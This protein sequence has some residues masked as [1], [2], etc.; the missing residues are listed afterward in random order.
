MPVST[1]FLRGVL[2]MLCVFFAY[3]AGRSVGAVRQGWS[4]LWRL[5]GWIL[6]TV[7]CG[8]VMVFRQ[9]LDGVV[10]AVWALA[11]MAF[12]GGMWLVLHQEPPEDLTHQI[13]PE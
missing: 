10:I 13:F 7:I 12:A 2:G 3:M 8:A 1:E 9:Q 11:A 6:R 5:Y 4:K